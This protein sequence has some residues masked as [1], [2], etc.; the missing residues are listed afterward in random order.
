MTEDD[1][2][3]LGSL[4]SAHRGFERVLLQELRRLDGL[5]N[6]GTTHARP[7]SQKWT[8]AGFPDHTTRGLAKSDMVKT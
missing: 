5:D 6:A 2:H 4:K 8:S 1:A 3:G 7:E